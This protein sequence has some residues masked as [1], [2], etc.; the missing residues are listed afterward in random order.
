MVPLSGSATQAAV[1]YNLTSLNLGNQLAGTAGQGQ[2]I[3]A[4]NSGTG[5]THF[6]KNCDQWN[7][8]WGFWRDAIIVQP[9]S[10]PP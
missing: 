1:S 8:F 3:Q 9:Q 6:Y 2:A 7:E 5:I 4:T 10:R